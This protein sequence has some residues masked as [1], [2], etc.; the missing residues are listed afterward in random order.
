[1]GERNIM[2]DIAPLT[3]YGRPD[4]SAVARVMWT[5]GELGLE[6]RRIDWGGSYGGNDDPAYRVLQPAGRIPAVVLP[7]GTALW[8][9]NAIIRC[10]ASL[11]DPGGLIPSDPVSRAE[12]EAWMEYAGSVAA[13]V[14]AV[15]GAYKA[16]HVD[17]DRLAAAIDRAG[18]VLGVLERR[19]ADGGF[20][21]PAGFGVADLATGVWV[22]RWF[23]APATLPD[24]PALPALRDWYGRLCDRAAYRT[25][26][27][28]QV[29]SGP[30]RYP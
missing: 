23:R 11:H 9:S 15:R 30:Q 22:H 18:D 10:L 5:I 16:P 1:M 26:V 4:S 12:A 14:S 21:H 28:D 2:A 17:V 24:V 3:V 7:D 25:H 13:A 29:S 8:E 19:L 27:V 20:L 6:C